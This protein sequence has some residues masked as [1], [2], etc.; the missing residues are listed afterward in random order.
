MNSEILIRIEKFR[1]FKERIRGS[2][3]YLIVGI[4]ISKNQHHAFFG[5]ANGK[6]LKRRLIFKNDFN[7]FMN[8][9]SM[10][11]ALREQNGLSQIVFGMEPTGNY[12]KPLGMFLLNHNQEVVLVSGIA[13]HRNRE[14]LDGRWDKNDTKCNRGRC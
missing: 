7:G 9:I 13:T 10:A 5:S 12:H 11:E 1:Q 3:E 6:T 14:L 4:D 2:E 8:L